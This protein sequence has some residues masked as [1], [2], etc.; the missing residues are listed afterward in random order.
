MMALGI[1]RAE[2]MEWKKKVKRG[3]IALLTHFWY[4]AKFPQFNSVTK[5]GSVDIEKLLA[6]GE[7]YGLKAEW[8]HHRDEYPHFDLVGPRQKYI[9]E[10]EGLWE[11]IQRFKIK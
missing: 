2:L 5:A 11:H 10:Q 6:W 1:K 7:K 4:S 9:L 3:E 8:I